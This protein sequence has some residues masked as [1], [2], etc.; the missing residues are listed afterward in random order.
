MMRCISPFFHKDLKIHLACG[1]CLSCLVAKR[2]KWTARMLME[3][4]V[5]RGGVFLTLTY[6]DEN[7]PADLCVS[8]REVQLFMKRLRKI[9]RASLRYFACGEYGEKTFRPHYHL[10]LWGLTLA[11]AKVLVPKA[12]TFGFAKILALHRNRIE[13]VAGYVS[14]KLSSTRKIE[15]LGRAKE[16][17]LMSRRPALGSGYLETLK[18]FPFAQSS[19]DVLKVFKFGSKYYPLDR[20]IREKLRS[21]CM[22]EDDIEVVK[23]LT[24]E[25]LQDDLVNLARSSLGEDSALKLSN[26]LNLDPNSWE[27]EELVSLANLAYY[28]SEERENTLSRLR[29]NQRRSFRKDL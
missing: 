11:Q 1:R 14:K 6:S 9:S 10:V 24:I 21:S 18:K 12:W 19:Y 26:L 8:K 27:Y 29:Q 13:Y 22:T 15:E 3:A 7:L 17:H 28:Q 4:E 25:S 23:S 2:R 20:F 5:Q 16:F